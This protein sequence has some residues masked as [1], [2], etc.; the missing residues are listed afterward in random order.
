MS[1]V[2][3]NPLTLEQCTQ[4]MYPRHED[5]RG[6]YFRDQTAIIHSTPFARLKHK[7]QVFFAPENDHICTRIEHVLHVATVAATLCRGLSAQ[8]WQLDSDLAYTIGMGHDLGHAPFGHCGERTLASLVPAGVGFT[9]EQ[10]SL[11]VVDHLARSGR[12]LNLTLAVRDGILCHNGESVEQTLSP[13]VIFRLPE[14]KARL[15]DRKPATWEGCAVR[16]ADK[17]A[18]L[19]RDLEDAV[20]AGFVTLQDLPG[21][22][23]WELGTTNGEIINTLVIDLIETSAKNGIMGFSDE[24]YHLFRQMRSFNYRN[25][26]MH[27]AIMRYEKYCAEILR[28]L[29]H[30]FAGIYEAVKMGHCQP[31][32]EADAAFVAYLEEYAALYEQEPAWRPVTDYLAGMTD[33]YALNCFKQV[34]IPAPLQFRSSNATIMKNP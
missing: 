20:K 9:H 5:V 31:E 30:H 29:Y 13:D 4:R 7:A 24:K 10:H 32:L 17:I 28:M 21:E 23:R 16:F 27:R 2:P 25:I 22:I 19:G 11:R 6:P 8:G 12:G 26:Y 33:N 3:A 18:Y 34:T 15:R 1:R 14:H